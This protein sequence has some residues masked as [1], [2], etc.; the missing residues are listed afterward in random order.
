MA[1][2][3]THLLDEWLLVAVE[4]KYFKGS[5]KSRKKYLDKAFREV[6]QPLRYLLYGFDASVLW[7]IFS[8]DFDEQIIRA[9]SQMVLEVVKKLNLPMTYFPTK[10]VGENQFCAYVLGSPTRHDLRSLI[11]WMLNICRDTV[12]SPLLPSDDEVW[13]VAVSLG[14]SCWS[15]FQAVSATGVD[16][17]ITH[18]YGE[19]VRTLRYPPV[20][21]LLK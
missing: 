20:H 2:D 10:Y 13:G 3:Y 12:R 6:G 9:Y 14:S 8:E 5:S 19:G 15:S 16:P 4:I 11:G 18:V 7:H 17:V 21:P 1:E